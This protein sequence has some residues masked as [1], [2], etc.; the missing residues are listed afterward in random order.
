MRTEAF[1]YLVK[2]LFTCN[3]PLWK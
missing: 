3:Y 1:I 2:L